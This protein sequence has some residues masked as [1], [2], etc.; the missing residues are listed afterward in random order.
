M[1]FEIAAPKVAPNCNSGFRCDSSLGP[2]CME[3]TSAR[4]RVASNWCL[5]N[6]SASGKESERGVIT[7]TAARRRA[8]MPRSASLAAVAAPSRK[9]ATQDSQSPSV[10]MIDRAGNTPPVVA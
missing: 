6:H 2:G 9:N 4:T 10:R 7:A 5:K 8:G 1:R 3:S